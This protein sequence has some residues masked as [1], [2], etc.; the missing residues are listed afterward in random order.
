MI[1]LE[2]HFWPVNGNVH[3]VDGQPEVLNIESDMRKVSL[4]GQDFWISFLVDM[5]LELN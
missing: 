4:T 2:T 3:S 1:I 5:V